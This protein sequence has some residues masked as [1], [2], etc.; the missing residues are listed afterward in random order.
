MKKFLLPL[1]ILIAAALACA[2]PTSPPAPTPTAASAFDA[3]QTAHGFFVTPPQASLESVLAHFTALG[4][5]ADF[6]LIQQQVPWAEFLAGAEGESQGRTDLR[7]QMLL[8][9]QNGL[10]TV[11]VI[12]PLNGLNRR[13][14][15]GLPEGWQTSFADPN[16]RAALQHFAAWIVAEFQPRYLGLASEINT[17]ADAHPDDFP[18]FVSL[19]RE[20][21]AQVKAASPQTQVFT[22]F[23]WEDLNNLFPTASEGRQ[24]YQTNWQQVEV[25]ESQLDVWAISSYPY[26]VFSSGAEIPTDYYTPLATRTSKPLAVAEGGYI[27]APVGT[28]SGTPQDQVD[29]LNAIHAQ[30]GVRLVF[31]TYLLLNDLDAD[32]YNAALAEQGKPIDDLQSLG[33]FLTVGLRHADGT[34]K[35]ALDVWNSLREQP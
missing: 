19:Y 16:V 20:I 6:I 34:P 26:F 11:F 17:Y 24:P 10:D 31:W 8:A 2:Q 5:H 35:P 28:L 7:N 32:S 4:E 13:E 14:F 33:Y 23:Q 15:L 18:H 12:D 30:L 1:L 27:S 29:Y 21:Y 25:F 22:T 3:G 9:R